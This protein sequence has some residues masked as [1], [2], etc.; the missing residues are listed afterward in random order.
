MSKNE[1]DKN[2]LL[3]T[4]ERGLGYFVDKLKIIKEE[5]VSS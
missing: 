2:D 5:L 4:F 3:H 1:F